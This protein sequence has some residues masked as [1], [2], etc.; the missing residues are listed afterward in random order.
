MLLVDIKEKCW[1][2]FN[3]LPED[4]KELGYKPH[5]I[6]GETRNVIGAIGDERG[7]SV[8]QSIESMAGVESVFPILSRHSTVETGIVFSLIF[9]P[10]P[11]I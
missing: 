7:K 1:R 5:V 3:P 10:V 2:A 11:P 8:L 6:H 9:C 4:Q